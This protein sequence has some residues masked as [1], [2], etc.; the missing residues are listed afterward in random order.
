MQISVRPLKKL[1]TRTIS[2]LFLDGER[3]S[4]LLEDKVR[5]IPGMPVEQWKVDGQTAIPSGVFPVTLEHSG[6]F[7]PDTIT[8]NDVPGFNYIRCHGGNDEN[9][10]EGCPL[11]G[12]ELTDDFKIKPGTSSPAVAALKLKIRAAIVRGEHVWCEVTR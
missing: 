6:R 10:T 2:E 12:L 9:D 1:P 4:Y 5:E 8:I 11:P 3:F 7:G